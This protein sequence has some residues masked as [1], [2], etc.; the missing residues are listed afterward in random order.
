M[1]AVCSVEKFMERIGRKLENSRFAYQIVRFVLLFA[2]KP[3][4]IIYVDKT[5]LG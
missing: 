4:D 3:V 1:T 5:A 2:G